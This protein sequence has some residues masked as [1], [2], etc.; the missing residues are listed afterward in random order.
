MKMYSLRTA[1][2]LAAFIGATLG[3]VG[4]VTAGY[5]TSE[6]TAG[7]LQG[8][9]S[10]VEAAGTQLEIAVNELTNLV[11]APQ[12]DLRPQFNR[13]AAAVKKL[14]SVSNSVHKVD[15]DLLTRGRVH[16]D[17][18]DKELT[19]I[20]SEAIR[21]SGQARKLELQS[22]FDAVRNKCLTVLTTVTPLQSDLNDVYRFLNSDLT[23]GGLAAIRDSANRVSQQ[24][25]PVRESVGGLISELRSLAVAVSPQNSAAP[26][27][28]ASPK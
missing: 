23:V 28:S 4:C 25:A 6:R 16:F 26:A 8:L 24:A 1:I 2:A 27:A 11:N 21:S 9:A 3:L 17:Q 13:F 12:P 14:N 10:K 7:T 15:A 19:A 20:Q 22:R 18:W 5:R